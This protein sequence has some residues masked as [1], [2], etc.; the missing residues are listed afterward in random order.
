MSFHFADIARQAAADRAISAQEILE[1]RRAGWA[2]GRMGHEEA[3][4]LFKAQDALVAPSREWTDFFVE[5]IRNYV[6]EQAEPRG[7]VSDDVA[8]WLVTQVEGDGRICSMAELE[9]LVQI[10][11]K[12]NNVPH[13]LKTFVLEV[14]EEEVMTG[15][16]PTRCGGELADTHVTAAEA[17]MVRRVIFGQG[18]ETPAGVSCSE[19]E[20]LFRIKDAVA[21]ADNAPE[22]RK[23]FVQGVGNYLMGFA[24]GSAQITRERARELEGFI[25]D[26]RVQVG[27]FIGR[28]ANSAPN[29]FGKVFG[30]KAVQPARE[31]HVAQAAEVT[32]DEQTW[33]NAQIAANGTVDVYDQALLDFLAEET[34]RI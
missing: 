5:A 20:M 3:Q 17:Q 19:A 6:L 15:T 27:R 4:A 16:G 29:A 11:E 24:G 26:N 23:L 18:S 31:E 12:A 8:Q 33:L 22:F 2:D 25:A 21:T 30:R 13:F 32:G 28:M 10:V 34:D 14:I 9:L 1:L 7:F